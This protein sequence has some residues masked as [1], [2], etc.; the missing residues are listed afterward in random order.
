MPA[1]RAASTIARALTSVADQTLKPRCVIVVDDG[2]PDDT[3]A[4]ADACRSSM[5]GID[6]LVIKQANAGP[7]AARNR[8]LGE[9]KTGYVAFLD[10]D[11]EWL[12][13]KL[14]QSMQYMFDGSYVMVAHDSVEIIGERTI[15]LHCAQRYRDASAAPY[16][17]LYRRGFIDTTTV[18][19][20][21]A[22]V[23]AAGGFD[24]TLPNAQDFELWLAML[25]P[26]DARF[27]VFDAILSRYHRT[28][29]SVMTHIERR[30]KCCMQIALRYAPALRGHVRYPL[31]SLWF[32][33]IA[34]H[35]EAYVAHR[36]VGNLPA[37]LK[38]LVT[39][40]FA[41]AWATLIYLFGGGQRRGRYL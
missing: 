24:E 40:P 35:H 8:A 28:A 39:L 10:A 33:S 38:T 23:R 7:G 1:Y 14:A 6:L 11:D 19:A 15:T 31:P 2:S 36:A 37:A 18:V 32:R 13:E 3:F 17:G 26:K 4:V 20:K 25:A 27:F 30:R 16:D 29:G 22:A 12:A 21:L 34:V 41:T 9:A 5:N